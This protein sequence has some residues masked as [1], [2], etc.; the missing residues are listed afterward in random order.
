MSD[1]GESDQPKDT[2]DSSET[3]SAGVEQASQSQLL[4]E[5]EE[6]S[7][8][9]HTDTGLMTPDTCLEPESSEPE[10]NSEK[11]AVDG[12]EKL[13]S[14]SMPSAVKSGSTKEQ[15][16]S[17]D[18]FKCE[19]EEKDNEQQ[20]KIEMFQSVVDSEPMTSGENSA[21]QLTGTQLAADIISTSSAPRTDECQTE[22]SVV[23]TE[24]EL[25][26]LDHSAS[27]ADDKCNG[28]IPVAASQD[29]MKPDDAHTEN[30]KEQPS[31]NKEADITASVE[32]S[33]VNSAADNEGEQ[34]QG[35]VH[36][37]TAESDVKKHSEQQSK[38]DVKD[39]DRYSR[40]LEP[41]GE[42]LASYDRKRSR[43]R[44]HDSA[45]SV[46]TPEGQ[47]GAYRTH[48]RYREDVDHSRQ[49][50]KERSTR[51][52][53]RHRGEHDSDWRLYYY[54]DTYYHGVR[55]RDRSRE[56]ST[57]SDIR[58]GFSELEDISS[59]EG[60]I[61]YRDCGNHCCQSCHETFETISSLLEH[62]QS[63]AHEQVFCFY[64]P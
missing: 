47:H 54:G 46:T 63:A 17:Q 18:E 62:L 1:G 36:T 4:G 38:H 51:H 25:P 20:D 6:S 42:D 11:V 22:T 45:R 26:Q 27:S 35:D 29:E 50:T 58:R 10:K 39:S 30:E 33:R 52:G 14:S 40:Y 60:N 28:S 48:P 64:Q 21:E 3:K 57:R 41:L 8:Q 16:R 7:Q 31:D 49:D 44:S 37:Q 32:Q 13:T 34:L 9:Q 5:N 15:D 53:D 59:D 55:H 24:A 23:N 61:E 19:A 2:S 56:Y 43:K 12:T